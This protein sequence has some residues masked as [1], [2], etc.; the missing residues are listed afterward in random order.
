MLPEALK[1]LFVEILSPWEN[2]RRDSSLLSSLE[3]GSGRP[4]FRLYFWDRLCLS[5]GLN[6]KKIPAVDL[7]IVRRPTGGGALL[8][9]WDLSF[10]LVD[11][12]E[13]WGRSPKAIYKKVAGLLIEAFS[14]HGI[15][16]KMESFRGNYMNSEYCF[17]VPTFG[18]LTFKGRKVVSMAMR[19]LRRSF[20]IHGSI[21]LKFDYNRASRILNIESELLKERVAALVE[22]GVDKGKVIELFKDLHS[23][24][25]R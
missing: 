14:R 24:F 23:S 18:E 17:W 7:P 20:L 4:S 15:E 5:I 9:G 3:E 10:A 2:M 19:T 25:P 12:R 22:V 13:R 8:H 16:L 11:L 6:Q 21:Y 1:A